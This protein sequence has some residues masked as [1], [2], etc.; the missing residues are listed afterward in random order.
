MNTIISNYAND[1]LAITEPVNDIEWAHDR[2][3]FFRLDLTPS[4]SLDACTVLENGESHTMEILNISASGLYCQTSV[5][6]N[7]MQEFKLTAYFI[8]PL[9][10]PLVL[11]I[12]CYIVEVKWHPVQKTTRIRLEFLPGLETQNQ[13][14]IHRYI[15]SKQLQEL[16][17]ENVY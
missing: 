17:K 3:D 9:D 6:H 15:I 8:L 11:K 1:C 10:E 5:A 7:F 12:P 2:R 14:M 4:E 13:D 16:R